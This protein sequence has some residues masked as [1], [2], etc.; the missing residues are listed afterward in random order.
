MDATFRAKLR[1]LRKTL[2]EALSDAG[3]IEAF[4]V[5]TGERHLVRFTPDVPSTDRRKQ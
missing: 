5:D 1:D 3:P 4:D 2:L